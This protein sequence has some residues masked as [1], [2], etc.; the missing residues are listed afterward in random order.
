MT[1]LVRGVLPVKGRKRIECPI[2]LT[3][4][5]TFKSF[6]ASSSN[7]YFPWLRQTVSIFHCLLRASP[8]E[9]VEREKRFPPSFAPMIVA[10]DLMENLWSFEADHFRYIFPVSVKPL[11]VESDS[12][13]NRCF[14]LRTIENRTNSY[15]RYLH[16]L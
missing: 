9:D 4:V 3:D 7:I 12:Y 2:L 14:G 6:L 11:F 8:C 1:I 16:E 13:S 10:A 5:G 15:Q